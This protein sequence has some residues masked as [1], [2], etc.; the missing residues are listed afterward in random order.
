MFGIG[1]TEGQG[2]VSLTFGLMRISPEPMLGVLRLEEGGGKWGDSRVDL[3]CRQG[4]VGR[5]LQKALGTAA[6]CWTGTS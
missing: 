1:E 2:W 3:C 5:T 6:T 4:D